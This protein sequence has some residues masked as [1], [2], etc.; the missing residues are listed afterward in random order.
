MVVLDN[1]LYEKP[2]DA[3]DAYRILSS[4]SNRTHEVITAVTI[5]H[6]KQSIT[7]VSS[8]KVTFYPLSKQDIED[9]IASQEPFDKAGAY[10]IQGL[11]AKFIRSIEGDYYT[12]MG[13]P[14]AEV[15]W[16]LKSWN[17]L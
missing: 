9:Y 2:V 6:Q 11:G 7:I 15:Y 4:L 12:I 17:V 13:F 5:M 3:N 14:I 1:Q 16:Q 8:A 10:A